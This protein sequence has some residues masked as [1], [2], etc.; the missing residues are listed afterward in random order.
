MN[1]QTLISK[2]GEVILYPNFFTFPES[3]DLLSQLETKILWRQDYIKIHGKTL[4]MPRLTAFYGDKDITYTY[5]RI[6]MKAE[7]WIPELLAIKKRIEVIAKVNFNSVLLNLYRTGKDSMSWHSDDEPE[8]GKNPIIASVSLGE[9]RRFML[10][11]KYQ[12]DLPSLSVDLTS[13]S[14]LL[15]QGNTQHFWQHQIPKSQKSLGKRINLTFRII[16]N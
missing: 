14:F 1:P 16:V 4:A 6:T 2:D 3:K 13:G 15:M 7:A 9:T 8:L 11:H 5:S 10:K 12:K